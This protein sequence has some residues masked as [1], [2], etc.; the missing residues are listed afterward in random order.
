MLLDSPA[1]STLPIGLELLFGNG[2]AVVGVLMLVP[3][4]V[5]YLFSQR[6]IERGIFSG[7]VTG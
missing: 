6:A 5:L 7:A 3:A 2:S 1:H 4:L